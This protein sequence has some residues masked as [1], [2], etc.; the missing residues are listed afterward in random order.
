[1]VPRNRRMSATFDVVPVLD[2]GHLPDTGGHAVGLEV[3]LLALVA[4]SPIPDHHEEHHRIGN[5]GCFIHLDDTF[6]Q[7]DVLGTLHLGVEDAPN[8]SRDL[9][10]KLGKLT[11]KHGHHVVRVG[12]LPTCVQD[13]AVDSVYNLRLGLS[14]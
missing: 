10:P 2:L 1:M 4:E 14:P 9:P 13:E 12:L 6:R 3:Q 7:S 8:V 11:T 5:T